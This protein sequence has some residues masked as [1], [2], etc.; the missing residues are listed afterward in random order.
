MGGI[1]LSIQTHLWFRAGIWSKLMPLRLQERWS[2]GVRQQMS[3][4][5]LR[6]AWMRDSDDRSAAL[7]SGM[8]N[9]LPG[10][11]PDMKTFLPA[12]L[13]KVSTVPASKLYRDGS[14]PGAYAGENLFRRADVASGLTKR[15]A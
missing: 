8:A 14:M 1:V 10:S 2:I 7:Q 15:L 12:E 13:W 4:E 3:L 9:A 5:R 11:N 6:L